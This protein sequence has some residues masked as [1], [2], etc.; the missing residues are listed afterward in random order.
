VDTVYFTTVGE[1]GGK[2]GAWDELS[3]VSG[4]CSPGLQAATMIR[5]SAIERHL[6]LNNLHIGGVIIDSF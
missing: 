6:R 3:V 2:V 4:A 5:E 1:P